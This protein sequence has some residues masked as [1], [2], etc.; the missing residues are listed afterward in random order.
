[1]KL[2]AEFA[3]AAEADVF[4]IALRIAEGSVDAAL[5]WE[6]G[7]RT[8][9][10]SLVRFPRRCPVVSESAFFGREVRRLAY[11]SYR[12]LYEI[13]GDLV[14]ILRVRHGARRRLGEEE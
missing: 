7:V 2:R 13:K 12:V 1:M 11:G 10:A 3:A 9:A 4:E 14:V 8:A 5:R 6:S